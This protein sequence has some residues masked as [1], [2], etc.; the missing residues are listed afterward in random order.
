MPTTKRTAPAT[1]S[2]RTDAP[3]KRPHVL[4]AGPLH[5]RRSGPGWRPAKP[6]CGPGTRTRD[7]EL[8]AAG[9]SG[10]LGG[11]VAALLGGASVEVA[12]TAQ[13][14]NDLFREDAVHG[15]EHR[16]LHRRRAPLLPR[17]R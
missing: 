7:R 15:A 14:A 17:Q 5:S 4:T 12:M 3:K 8:R 2:G 9:G 16:G 10:G 6:Q 11:L 1:N 13:P